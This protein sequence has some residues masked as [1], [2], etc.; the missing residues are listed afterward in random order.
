MAAKCLSDELHRRWCGKVQADGTATSGPPV[1]ATAAISV[2]QPEC[3][4][5]NSSAPTQVNSSA[6]RVMTSALSRFAIIERRKHNSARHLQTT[7]TL[8]EKMTKKAVR[9]KHRCDKNSAAKVRTPKQTATNSD[10]HGGSNKQST[11]DKVHTC[12]CTNWP[13]LIERI[14]KS[15]HSIW[16]GHH[17]HCEPKRSRL[18]RKRKFRNALH[19]GSQM[20]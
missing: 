17:H 1:T 6:K 13:L 3:V 10:A 20:V 16:L 4:F 15:S 2:V 8:A 7:I 18:Q 11:S 9:H 19:R 14:D 5:V 12:T